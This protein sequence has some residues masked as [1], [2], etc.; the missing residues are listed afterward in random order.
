[1]LVGLVYVALWA[2]RRYYADPVA[3]PATRPAAT[4]DVP[5]EHR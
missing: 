4:S 5:R 2:R 3:G 1:M